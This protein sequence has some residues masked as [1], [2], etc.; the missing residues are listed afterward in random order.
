M[1]IAKHSRSKRP[2]AFRQEE[3]FSFN[4]K[5][6]VGAIQFESK[7]APLSEIYFVK[8]VLLY[9]K[10][11]NLL[12]CNKNIVLKSFIQLHLKPI[13]KIISSLRFKISS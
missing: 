9:N 6:K 10:A 1:A 2:L 7:L 13:V 5:I 12:S 3:I 4:P 11:S 8:N